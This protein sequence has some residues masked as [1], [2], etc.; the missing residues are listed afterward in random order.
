MEFHEPEQEAERR[1]LAKQWSGTSVMRGC[2]P[3]R[4]QWGPGDQPV[5]AFFSLPSFPGTLLSLTMGLLSPPCFFFFFPPKFNPRSLLPFL[6]LVSVSTRKQNI[7]ETATIH[8]P[9]SPSVLHDDFCPYRR[10][11]C[12][13]LRVFFFFCE[14][15]RE[16]DGGRRRP[17]RPSPWSPY[18]NRLKASRSSALRGSL[19]RSDFAT[20]V[21]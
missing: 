15:Q 2:T 9:P 19:P 8:S 14:C 12:A 7:V 5:V 4:L 21:R 13:R 20:R 1:L 18:R 10:S 11:L 16:A 6:P 3:L 17:L